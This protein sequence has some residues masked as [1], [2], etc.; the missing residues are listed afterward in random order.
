VLII[1]ALIYLT[2]LSWKVALTELLNILQTTNLILGTE[3]LACFNIIGR[4]FSQ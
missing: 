2:Y 3:S 4:I 1:Y